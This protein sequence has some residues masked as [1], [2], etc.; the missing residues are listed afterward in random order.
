VSRP[1]GLTTTSYAVLGLLALRDWS[2]YELAQQMQRSMRLWWPRAAS[3]V[4]EEPKRLVRLGLATR[5]REPTGRRPRTVY[6]ITDDGRAVLRGW[7]TEPSGSFRL[8]FEGMLKVFFGDQSDKAA[9]LASIAAVRAA[10]RA[11]QTDGLAVYEDYGTT[12]GP[13]PERLHIIALVTDFY[14]RFLTAIVDWADA[15]E[16]EV[17]RWPSTTDGPERRGVFE[18]RVRNG[19][20]G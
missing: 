20:R 8:E 2:T 9:V 19:V 6:G 18:E 10:A 4:Y 1:A 15:A 17:G 3:R 11:D 5:R 14:D 13:F 7:L 16:V 12:G